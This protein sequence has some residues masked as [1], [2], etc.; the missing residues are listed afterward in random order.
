MEH[1]VMTLTEVA[2]YLKTHKSTIYKM[3]KRKQL[4]AFRVGS[5]YR[6]NRSQIDEWR[7]AQERR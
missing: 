1:E 5:D 3:L 7:L 2:A 6:F 4:P